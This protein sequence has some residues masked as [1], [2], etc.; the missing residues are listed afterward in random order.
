MLLAIASTFGLVLKHRS[1]N[2]FWSREE[3]VKA[4]TKSKAIQ[5]CFS[6]FNKANKKTT[7]FTNQQSISKPNLELKRCNVKEERFV[8]STSGGAAATGHLSMEEYL[9]NSLYGTINRLISTQQQQNTSASLSMSSG[10]HNTHS[11]VSRNYNSIRNSTS[12][13]LPLSADNDSAEIHFWLLFYVEQ[14]IANERTQCIN[15]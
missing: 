11:C 13:I 8:T 1:K 3:D 12:Y 6:I 14:C 10:E 7:D 2:G 9:N 4:P 5:R 15:D